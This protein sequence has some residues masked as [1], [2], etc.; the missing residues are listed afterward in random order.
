MGTSKN[1]QQVKVNREGE[2]EFSSHISPSHFTFFHFAVII[3]D[4]LI[5]FYVK[6]TVK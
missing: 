6:R 2:S 1:S 5:L 4:V 3:R